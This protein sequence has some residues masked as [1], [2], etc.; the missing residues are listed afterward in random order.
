MPDDLMTFAGLRVIESPY[1]EEDGEPYT[2]R[3]T[4]RD[5]LLTRPWRPWVT[6]R[7]VVPRVPYRGAMRIDANTIVMHPA[8]VRELRAASRMEGR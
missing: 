4:W 1:L 2:I 3:R 8:V 7:T 6:T 5:R